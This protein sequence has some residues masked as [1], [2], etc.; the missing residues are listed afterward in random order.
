MSK[1]QAKASPRTVLIK[2]NQGPKDKPR[3]E[4]QERGE[5]NVQ[6]HHRCHLK[7]FFIKASS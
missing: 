1:L 4:G 2:R 6:A 7:N 3:E 5:R